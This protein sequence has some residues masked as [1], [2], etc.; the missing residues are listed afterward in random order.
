MLIEN[1][2]VGPVKEQRMLNEKIEGL[3]DFELGI[4]AYLLQ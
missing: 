4:G 1:D 3:I 2:S